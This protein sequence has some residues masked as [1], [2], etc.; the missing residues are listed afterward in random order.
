MSYRLTRGVSRATLS[1]DGIEWLAAS[2]ATTAIPVTW[3][4]P[5][6][7]SI[8]GELL[9]NPN[10]S[11][12]SES[13]EQLTNSGFTLHSSI[14][15]PWTNQDIGSPGSTGSSDYGFGEFNVA[16][17]GDIWDNADSLQ[18]V[19]TST[20]G[21][22]DI[23]ALISSESNGDTWAKTGVMIRETL[24]EGSKNAF[25]AITPDNGTSFQYRENTDGST[26]H[27]GWNS[28][29]VV[30]YWVRLI[31][32]GNTFSGHISSDGIS[33]SLV[34]SKSIPMSASIYVGL[35]VSSGDSNL[36]S[37]VFK[38][39]TVGGEVLQRGW[40]VSTGG[41]LQTEL[42]SG[43]IQ[44]DGAAVS[45]EQSIDLPEGEYIV[46]PTRTDNSGGIKIKFDEPVTWDD[47]SSDEKWINPGESEGFVIES[48]ALPTKITL[49]TGHQ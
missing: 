3:S 34:Q 30:P 5:S 20:T 49:D 43:I 16:G 26:S 7:I 31:R 11:N 39:V 4:N 42:E 6:E 14:P 37:V 38:N 10:F 46:T 27:S 23:I 22:V 1:K 47:G 40:S 48:T 12:V 29:P 13:V 35:A 19:S 8:G 21:D 2:T 25:M 15:S 36:S 44:G 41:L 45:I 18:Y 32:S 17:S 9:S 24:G 28:G 33:W